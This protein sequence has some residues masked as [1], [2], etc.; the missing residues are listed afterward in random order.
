MKSRIAYASLLKSVTNYRYRFSKI[1]LICRQNEVREQ[2]STHV[3]KA[4]KTYVSR[5][6]LQTLDFPHIRVLLMECRKQHSMF[7]Y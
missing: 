1:L 4:F 3:V 5:V 7:M 6:L 2:T